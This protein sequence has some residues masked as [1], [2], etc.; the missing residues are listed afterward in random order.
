MWADSIGSSS[1]ST[2]MGHDF[3]LSTQ[4]VSTKAFI[5][6]MWCEVV[7]IKKKNGCEAY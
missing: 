2:L 6:G 3:L 7:I 5:I 4:R 1:A